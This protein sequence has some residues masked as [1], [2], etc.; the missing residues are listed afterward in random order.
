MKFA[1]ASLLLI[2]ATSL[3]ACDFRSETA[4]REMEKFTS[5]PTPTISPTPPPAPINPADVVT[6]DVSQDGPVIQVNGNGQTKSVTCNKFNRVMVN[7]DKNTVTVKGACRQ[8][9]VNGDNHQLT[10]D[11]SVEFVVNGDSNIIRYSRYVNGKH[12]LVR[13]NGSG[14]AVE[15]SSTAANTK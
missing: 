4:K 6:A 1:I 9:T 11:A 15:K 10:T 8:V 3:L 12:P 7:G 5:S 14:N 2:I 13:D